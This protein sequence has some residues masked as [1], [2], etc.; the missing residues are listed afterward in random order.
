MT[1]GEIEETGFENVRIDTP[2][3]PGRPRSLEPAAVLALAEI[4]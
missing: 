3:A 1:M 4:V 2:A